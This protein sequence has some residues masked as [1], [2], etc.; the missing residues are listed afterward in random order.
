MNE[1]LTDFVGRIVICRLLFNILTPRGQSV[2]VGT[3]FVSVNWPLCQES[4]GLMTSW[5]ILPFPVIS[6]GLP[7][8]SRDSG[9]GSVRETGNAV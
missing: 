8:N 6:V 2:I 1:L 9:N 4:R 3:D 5:Y 7:T